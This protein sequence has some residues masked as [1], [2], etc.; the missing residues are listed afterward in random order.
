MM[1]LAALIAWALGYWAVFDPVSL[2]VVQPAQASIREESPIVR[3]GVSYLGWFDFRTGAISIDL[4]AIRRMYAG[5]E[6]GAADK[7]AACLAVHEAVH[8]ELG[9]ASHRLPLL[10]QYVCL[11]RM[12]APW[13]MKDVVYQQLAAIMAPP[14]GM[15][16]REDED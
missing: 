8:R 10:H 4:P 15:A 2:A 11:D 5:F 13:W 1:N 7:Y 12:G 16:E 3:G 9:N 6:P 14:V